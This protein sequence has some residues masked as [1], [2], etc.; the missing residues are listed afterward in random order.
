[1]VLNNNGAAELSVLVIPDIIQ[2]E[3]LITPNFK[4]IFVA[5]PSI[6]TELFLICNFSIGVVRPIP[7]LPILYVNFPL[8]TLL[9]VDTFPLTSYNVHGEASIYLEPF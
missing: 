7:T 3:L 8:F 5:L 1:M 6:K 2:L 4:N 9:F